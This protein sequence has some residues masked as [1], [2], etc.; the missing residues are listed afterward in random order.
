MRV[1]SA[2]VPVHPPPALDPQAP[3]AWQN[4]RRRSPAV[5]RFPRGPPFSSAARTGWLGE[6]R[7]WDAPGPSTANLYALLADQA[8]AEER[9]TEARAKNL[10]AAARRGRVG[11]SKFNV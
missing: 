10:A 7:P 3:R 4:A 6:R 11:L 8:V 2:P 9:A 5:A 1:A